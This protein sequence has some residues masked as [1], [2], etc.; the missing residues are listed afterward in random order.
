V[1]EQLQKD[2]A[3]DL[4]FV[5]RH[6]PLMS[7]HDKSALAAQAAEAAGLQDKFWDMHYYLF[8]HPED[9]RELSLEE[10]QGWVVDRAGELGMDEDQFYDDMTSVEVVTKVRE[11]YE[12]NSSIGMPG[13]PFLVLNGHPFSSP[14]SY[15]NLKAVFDA[16]LLE[17]EQFTDCPPMTIDTSKKY[18]A[19][20]E[21]E[22]GDIV[23]ELYAKDAPMAV[24]N[25]VFLSRN[26]WYDGVAFHRVIPDFVAQTGDPSG[27][28][29]GGPGYAFSNEISPDL[30]FD[31]PGVVGMANAGPGTNG[32]QFFIAYKALP[33]LDGGYTIFGKVISGMDVLKELTPRNPS[34]SMTLPPGDKII[35]IKIEER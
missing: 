18:L 13:T 2:Y 14:V 33:N 34:E 3:D 1:L 29:L 9:W 7:I 26:G 16:T 32:S 15:G 6:F 21:T 12:H 24:N 27:T 19:T 31:G 28:G 10:F 5:Y 4:R 17:R 25:F 30:K 23:L 22:K 8:A 35:T 20:I 11:A